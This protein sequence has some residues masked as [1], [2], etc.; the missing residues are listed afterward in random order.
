M[1][2]ALRKPS[3]LAFVDDRDKTDKKEGLLLSTTQ[4]QRELKLVIDMNDPAEISGSG[5]DM[6]WA[7]EITVLSVAGKYEASGGIHA[8]PGRFQL[9]GNSFEI[10]SGQITLPSTGELDPFI[11]IVAGTS[12][13]EAD[14]TVKVRGRASRPELSLSSD[15]AM[16][17]YQIVSLLVA[18]RS[19][20]AD[21]GDESVQTQAA[22][23]LLAFQNPLL[24][25][26]LYSRLGV[27]RVDVAIGKS[28]E[29]PIVTVGK[30]F[31]RRVYVE[32]EYHHNAPENENTAG[33]RIEY[34]LSPSWSLETTYGDANKGEVGVFWHKRFDS[35][36]LEDDKEVT[37]DE[38]EN[39]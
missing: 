16:S 36:G 33:A 11:D 2:K 27:D 4:E 35:P 34:E 32:T 38:E 6:R 13:A 19:D 1:P 31:G 7:G 15:P 30:R 26:Q 37:L 14:V 21:S 12:T 10:D 24:E 29:E 8:S 22:S 18:G 25:R 23:L 17:Q 5:V 3:N 28:V 39:E 9:L 20:T